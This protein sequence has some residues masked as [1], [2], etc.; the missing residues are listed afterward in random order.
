MS[1]LVRLNY[2]GIKHFFIN[3][4][5]DSQFTLFSILKN[6]ALHYTL[7]SNSVN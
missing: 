3:E 2:Q 1:K 5:M 4:E 6:F 7:I